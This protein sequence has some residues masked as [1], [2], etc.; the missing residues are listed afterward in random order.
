MKASVLIVGNFLSAVRGNHHPCEDLA[1]RLAAQQWPVIT[2]SH[3][4]G[5]MPR[6]LDMVGTAWRRRRH[7]DVA[8]VDVYSGLSF[9]WAEAVCATLRLANKPYVL[10]L[11][12]GRLPIFAARWPNRVKR[13]LSSAAAVTTPSRYLYESM[14]AYGA[15]LCL[16]PNPLELDAYEFRPRERPRPR[17]VWLRAFHEVYNPT[18][19]VNTL[20]LLAPDFHDAQLLMVGHDKGDGSLA[21][22]HE[23]AARRGVS[24]RLSVPGGV[25]K[26]EIA[27]WLNRGDIFLN[28]TNADNAPVSIVEA[29]ACGLCIVSTNVGGIPYLLE[30]ERDALL[31]PPEDP[32]A[33]A[34]AV[35]RLLVEPELAARLS[36]QARRKAEQ[37]DWSGVL[38][39]WKAL[40]TQAAFEKSNGEFN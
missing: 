36:R 39:K 25:A 22:V 12:G 15:A 9:L 34:A 14:S 3:K 5:R 2:T 26:T 33:M 20:A 38:P 1:A 6:L 21:R 24:Q 17:L 4:L 18:L 40:L 31:V 11:H 7:Y 27:D 19:A 16:Q 32:A 30:H 13:L 35:R 10:T 23:L 8:H 37:F 28:T 29:M